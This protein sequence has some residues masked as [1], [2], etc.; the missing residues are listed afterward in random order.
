MLLLV[1]LHFNLIFFS[2]GGGTGF[3]GKHLKQYLKDH[4]YDVTV[5]SRKTNK[6]TSVISWVIS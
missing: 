4:N 5:I 6:S 1:Y 3:V 2:P